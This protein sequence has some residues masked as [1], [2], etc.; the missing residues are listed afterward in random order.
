LSITLLHTLWFKPPVYGLGPARFLYK[1]FDTEPTPTPVHKA[2][3][4]VLGELVYSLNS[5]V[6]KA[7]Y[8]KWKS[9]MDKDSFLQS[10]I[11]KGLNLSSLEKEAFAVALDDLLRE[12]SL[13]Y[14]AF[15]E[16]ATAKD[17]VLRVIF[18]ILVLPVR[19][20][21]SFTQCVRQMLRKIKNHIFPRGE[22]TKV[23]ASLEN[24]SKETSYGSNKSPAS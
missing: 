7:K 9:V 20:I 2:L 23:V 16:K 13:S 18:G 15:P 10:D 1:E 11:F 24:E 5:I 4:P 17:K 21:K 14:M 22:E 19:I 8:L 12:H 6:E 3:V